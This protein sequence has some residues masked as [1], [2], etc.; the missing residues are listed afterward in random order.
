M[1]IPGRALGLAGLLLAG[2]VWA[3]PLCAKS[4]EADPVNA[5]MTRGFEY[6]TIL[7]ILVPLSILAGLTLTVLRAAR[8]NNPPQEVLTRDKGDLRCV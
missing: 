2:R 5:G 6:I 3:C 8:R 7:L 4:I 1:A